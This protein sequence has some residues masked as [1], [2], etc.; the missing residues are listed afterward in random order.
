M[1]RPEK[2][3]EKAPRKVLSASLLSTSTATEYDP[4][5]VLTDSPHPTEISLGVFISAQLTPFF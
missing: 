3:T 5:S 2:V 4:S 1:S